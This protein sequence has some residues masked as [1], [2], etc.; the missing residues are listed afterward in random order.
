MAEYDISVQYQLNTV[1]N[2]KSNK[3]NIINKIVNIS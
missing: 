1:E 3:M 2:L